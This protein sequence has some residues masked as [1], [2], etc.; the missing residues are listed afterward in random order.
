MGKISFK[1]IP[2]PG[3]SVFNQAGGLIIITLSAISLFFYLSFCF[4]SFIH[5]LAKTEYPLLKFSFQQVN[6]KYIKM[7]LSVAFRQALPV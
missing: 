1:I 6:K 7:S 4:Y 5:N 3:K 2:A